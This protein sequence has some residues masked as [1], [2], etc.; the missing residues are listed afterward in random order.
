MMFGR[1]ELL[2]KRSD[3]G[4]EQAEMWLIAEYF[5]SLGHLSPEGLDALTRELKERC[6]F[7]PTIKECLEIINCGRYDWAN[8]FSSRP[9]RLY[10]ATAGNAALSAPARALSGKAAE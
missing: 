2:F 9:A 6:T 4:D 7:F 10:A 8:P 1:W 3:R 5:E